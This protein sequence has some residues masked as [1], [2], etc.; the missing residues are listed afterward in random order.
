ML[1]GDSSGQR[2]TEMKAR[3]IAKIQNCPFCGSHHY[4]PQGEILI[5]VYP[6]STIEA[7][8]FWKF[9]CGRCD[10]L[11]L[12]EVEGCAVPEEEDDVS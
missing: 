3:Q 5:E 10:R 9:H 6:G 1:R 4:S 8:P 7:Y 11:T 2:V 12:I